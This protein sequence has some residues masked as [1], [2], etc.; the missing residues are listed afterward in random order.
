MS[1]VCAAVRSSAARHSSIVSRSMFSASRSGPAS[2]WQW[3]QVMLQSLPTLI[4]KISIG[5]GPELGD[6]AGRRAR[7]GNRRRGAAT[8]RR[9]SSCAAVDASGEPRA[10]RLACRFGPRP[11]WRD[12]GRRRAF[13]GGRSRYIPALLH[14][15]A[16][17]HAVHERGA[18]A[19]RGG[20]V[21]GLGHLLE[22]GALLE[23]VLA[24]TRR[25]STGT[26]RRAPRPSAMSAFSR[27]LRAPSA[28]TAPYQAKNFS[29]RSLLP[30]AISPNFARCSGVVVGVHRCVP[31]RLRAVSD[32]PRHVRACPVSIVETGPARAPT[33][34]LSVCQSSPPA[35][36][37]GCQDG[38][39][40]RR[41]P[42]SRGSRS[43]RPERS[44]DPRACTSPACAAGRAPRSS[45]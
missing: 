6:A 8:T 34:R 43:R 11:G 9:S 3:R 39:A 42:S 16:H 19:D 31:P 45:S 21:D 2:T 35:A 32:R 40:S 14:V 36:A 12:R 26:G 28:K 5:A 22:V 13:H 20:D 18:A 7:V 38:G 1:T 10:R 27:S 15:L 44:R 33:P 4:W 29:A 25:C 41:R 30:S 37:G 23:A 17:L 24:C